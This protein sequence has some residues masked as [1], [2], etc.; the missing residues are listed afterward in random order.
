MKI[1]HV[2]KAVLVVICCAIVFTIGIFIIPIG[3]GLLVIWIVALMFSEE[4]IPSK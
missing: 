2:L 3:L 1:S 4:D